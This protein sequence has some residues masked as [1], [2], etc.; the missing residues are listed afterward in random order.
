LSCRF[1]IL[2]RYTLGVLNLFFGSAF[3]AIGFHLFTPFPF[4]IAKPLVLQN[5]VRWEGMEKI[6]EYA[7]ILDLLIKKY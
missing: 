6:R 7:K 5:P 3:N 2:H 4:F 1:A